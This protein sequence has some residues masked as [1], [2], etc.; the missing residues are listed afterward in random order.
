MK[1]VKCGAT[2]IN[3]LNCPVCNADLSKMRTDTT[4][5][6]QQASLSRNFRSLAVSASYCIT[7]TV[8][9]IIFGLFS[10]MIS[11]SLPLLLT[12]IGIIIF[13]R[14]ALTTDN[15]TV[16]TAPVN[17]ASA[18]VII[19]AVTYAI[20]DAVCISI[21]IG[22]K[23]TIDF[24]FNSLNDATG[25]D[26]VSEFIT[27]AQ[28]QG[29]TVNADLLYLSVYAVGIVGM[30]I[31][32]AMVIANFLELYFLSSLRS[33]IKSNEIKFRYLGIFNVVLLFKAIF[34]LIMLLFSAGISGMIIFGASA[35]MYFNAFKCGK[36]IK[37][38]LE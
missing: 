30:F 27:L 32:S 25:T 19:D 4:Y 23:Q 18:S 22:G 33:S 28:S 31:C 29:L 7:A 6:L 1:C 17:L 21:C 2:C 15:Y 35:F 5:L 36:S 26:I 20:Y 38:A 8:I 14:A 34:S 10:G 37:N 13:S 24:L 11:I 12:A 9:S 16:P 3:E